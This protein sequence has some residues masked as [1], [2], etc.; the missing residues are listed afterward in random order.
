VLVS[1]S[2]VTRYS[3]A[4]PAQYSIQSLRLTPPSFEGQQVV[5]W[6]IEMPRIEGAV[7][8]RD[9]F[10]NMAHQV[11]IPELHQQI[12]IVARG[13]VE[14][15][16]CAGFVRGLIEVG[17]SSVYKRE[18][19]TT[20]P[21]E[22]IEA[23]SASVAEEDAIA[24]M[25]KLMD[26]VHERVDYVIGVTHPHTSAA[27]ALQAGQGVCQ[28]HAH[29]FISAARVMGLPARYVN[30]YFLTEDDEPAE[31]HHAWA[32]VWIKGLGWLGFDPA[33]QVCPTDRYVRLACGLDSASA[34]PI[35][36]TRRGGAEEVL[37]VVVEVQ[38]QGSQQQ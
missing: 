8:F 6:S 3:L 13:T 21:D 30:G 34:A 38:Q 18:T 19:P 22:G 35:R 25:H 31:A 4:A 5:S 28:D 36:G 12:E 29:I 37:D 24:S 26:A 15:R 9:C 32:E 17:P 20:A 11:V 7:R 27:E 1:I 33:N 14:T 2:H 23:L 10:G 16:D